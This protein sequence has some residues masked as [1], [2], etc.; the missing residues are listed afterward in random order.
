MEQNSSTSRRGNVRYHPLLLQW[1]LNLYTKLGK[2]GYE[3]IQGH[4][5][6]PAAAYMRKRKAEIIGKDPEGVMRLKV[7]E[8]MTTCL[9][10]AQGRESNDGAKKFLQWGLLIFDGMKV[11]HG[12]YF[13]KH[14]GILVGHKDVEVDVI[15][16]KCKEYQD[17]H[18]KNLGQ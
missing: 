10:A 17:R 8:N 1:A 7:L 5:G 12:L 14:T 2:R 13:D 16:R 11:K 3:E 4:I 18:D 9:Q 15:V 6:L